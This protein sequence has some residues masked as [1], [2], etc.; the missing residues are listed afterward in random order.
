MYAQ[1]AVVTQEFNNYRVLQKAGGSS[2]EL[3]LSLV[4]IRSIGEIVADLTWNL[5][6]AIWVLV[7][8]IDLCCLLFLDTQ[9]DE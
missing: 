4:W 9:G 8:R 2:P 1:V 3:N 5:H 7:Y 6:G